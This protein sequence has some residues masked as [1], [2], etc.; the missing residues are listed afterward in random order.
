MC[1][2]TIESGLLKPEGI[3]SVDVNIE[4]RIDQKKYNPAKFDMA[5]IE[6]LFQRLVIMLIK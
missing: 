6:K 1:K 2:N 3:K 4:K 5:K